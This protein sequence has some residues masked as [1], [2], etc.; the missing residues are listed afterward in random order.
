MYK[1]RKA[2]KRLNS[3]STNSWTLREV[4]SFPRKQEETSY[5]VGSKEAL[6]RLSLSAN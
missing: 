1:G 6:K 3:L 5:L 2:S 4:E